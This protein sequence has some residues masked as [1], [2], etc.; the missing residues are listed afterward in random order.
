MYTSYL[1]PNRHLNESIILKN[2]SVNGN[3]CAGY[4][5][6]FITQ[7][8]KNTGSE[9]IEGLYVFPI[10]DTAFISGF[11]CEI[12]GKTLKAVIEDK[13]KIKNI[14]ENSNKRICRE[15]SMEKF[16]SN[17]FR[18]K[19]GRILSGETVKIKF[20][21]VDELKY[22]EGV[23]KLV[24]PSMLQP[25]IFDDNSFKSNDRH[26]NLQ[27]GKKIKCNNVIFKANIIVESLE[28]LEFK[29]VNHKINVYREGNSVTKISSQGGIDL[30]CK[31]FILTMKEKQT[32]EENG[33]IYNCID[34]NRKKG[35]VYIRLIPK[36][37]KFETDKKRKY[38]FVIDVSTSDDMIKHVKDSIQLCLRNMLMG[39]M[40]NIIATGDEV[41][42]F[43]RNGMVKYTEETLNSA[44]EWI[45]NLSIGKKND[46][47]SAFEY[48]RTETSEQ[49]IILLF[50]DH[51]V[52]REEATLE[53]IRNNM[54]CNNIYTFCI[55]RF[56]DTYLLNKFSGGR[57]G[58]NEVIDES[59][60]IEDVVLKQFTRIKSPKIEDVKIDWGKLKV[61]ATYPGTIDYIYNREVFSIF[62]V[63]EGDAAGCVVLSGKVGKGE[64]L[65]EIDI[66]SFNIE[67]NANLIRKVWVGKKIEAMENTMRTVEENKR[68]VT[69]EKIVELSKKEKIMSNET[70][71]VLMEL[72]EE[73]VIGIQIKN[74]V[75]VKWENCDKNTCMQA[76]S[77]IK[78]GFFYK[79]IFKNDNLYLKRKYPREKIMK[80]IAKSQFADGSF[81]D[82]E[83]QTIDEKLRLTSM[84]LLSFIIG[85]E[86]INIYSNQIN[87]AVKF[88][89]SNYDKTGA[90]HKDEILAII[91]LTLDR[92]KKLGIADEKLDDKLL[93][94]IKRISKMLRSSGKNE[95]II[96]KFSTMPF[97]RN[98]ASFFRKS[99]DKK[100]ID[101]VIVVTKGENLILNMAKL[102]ILMSIDV[103]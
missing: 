25:R 103:Q 59:K 66:D 32:L 30:I 93:E 43:S 29:S 85:D 46:L 63:V 82:I 45:E 42:V 1:K 74:I 17:V 4:G 81:R 71:F 39:D 86:N 33:M 72:M 11:E 10:P 3:I 50:N 67:E 9:D 21:Y 55:G 100:Y 68:E 70:D 49:S 12:G 18:I 56:S 64:F 83:N 91:L 23:F 19:I 37:D 8:Y 101:E 92:I 60:N 76:G 31:D 78:K 41:S 24:V 75:G 58:K 36:L 88:I 35:I 84:A 34:G 98:V 22:K 6:I 95:S 77:D 96:D 90:G 94:V 57:T 62:A 28:E 47:L 27:E 61:N 26:L 73:P 69:R 53:Y 14:C 48:L 44:S 52:E 13:K 89:C 38:I 54:N 40:F 20:S 87:K 5:E 51:G 65:K 15:F 7:I 79:K 97:K 102:A 2:A 16:E 80:I 99:R